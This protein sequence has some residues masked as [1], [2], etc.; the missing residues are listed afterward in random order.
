MYRIKMTFGSLFSGIL[1]LDIGFERAG[2]TPLWTC[3]REPYPRKVIAKHYPHL[4][5]YDDV[6]TLGIENN[7]ERPDVLIG[8]FPCTDI[9]SAHSSSKREGLAGDRSGLWFQYE[10]IIQKQ[11]P[12][13]TVVENVGR[14]R[15]WVPIVRRS[16]WREGY[17]SLPLQLCAAGFGAPHKRTRVFVIGYPDGDGESTR[18]LHAEVAKL[19]E[20]TGFRRPDRRDA[21]PGALGV[22]DGPPNK[23]DRLV[24]LGNAVDVRVSTAIAS[25]VRRHAELEG[26]W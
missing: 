24:A 22:D 14:W 23:M 12:R 15:A 6:Y 2:F 3:E 20:S 18:A 26:T 11:K 13:Y 9:S 25:L 4:P 17:A 8:G 7:P 19:Q 21:P 1:G 5:C 16:L 10:R